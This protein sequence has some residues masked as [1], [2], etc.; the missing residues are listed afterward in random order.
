MYLLSFFVFMVLCIGF[1]MFGMGGSIVY[2]MDAPSLLL[3]ALIVVPMLMSAG[4]LKDFNNAFRFGVKVKERVEKVELM[5]AVEAVTLAIKALWA[6]GI[7]GAVFQMILAISEHADNLELMWKY[8][9]VCLIPFSYAAFFVLLLMPLKARLN[10]LLNTPCEKNTNAADEIER[11][12]G[13]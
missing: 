9:S 2:F 7:F 12:G 3:I 6:A 1:L 11:A 13:L 10:V 5:R 8:V 4:L